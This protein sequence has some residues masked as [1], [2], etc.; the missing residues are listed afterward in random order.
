MKAEMVQAPPDPL[1]EA[2]NSFRKAMV[3]P[4]LKGDEML[5]VVLALAVLA[6]KLAMHPCE[7]ATMC[8][9]GTLVC[10]VPSMV[11]NLENNCSFRLSSLAC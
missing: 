5:S 10:C 6:C 7:D 8:W 11:T 1:S 4:I 2:K 9:L 3:N